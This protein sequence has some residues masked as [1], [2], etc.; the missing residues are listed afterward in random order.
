MKRYIKKFTA[1]LIFSAFAFFTVFFFA[2]AEVYLGNTLDF[3]VS[4]NSVIK[5][6]PVFAAAATLIFSFV[7]SFLPVKVLKIV[8]LSIFGIT[9]CFYIQAL[10]LNG[11]LAQLNGEK[12]VISKTTYISNIAIWIAILAVVFVCWLIFKKLKK[13]KAYITATKLVAVALVIMQL[14]GFISL[15]LKYDNSIS[16]LKTQ[17]LSS[18]GRFELSKQKNVVCFILDCAD[19]ETVNLALKEDP[20]MFAGLDGFTYYPDHIFIHGRTF[21]A[22]TYLLTKEK[23]YYDKPYQEYFNSACENSEFLA[24]LDSLCSD[25]RVYTEASYLGLTAMETVDNL[26]SNYSNDLSDIKLIG[27]IKHS[28]KISAF[29]EMPYLFKDYFAYKTEEV[30]KDSLVARDDVAPVN[31]DLEFYNTI[32]EQKLSLNESYSSAFRFYHMFGP[33]P[34]A[35]IDENAEYVA[36]ATLSQAMRGDMKIVK[37][38][39][40]QLKELGIYDNTTIIITADHGYFSGNVKIPQNCLLLV[41]EANADT[42]QP[43]KIS[44]AQVSQEDYFATVIKSFGGDYSKFGKAYDDISETE[45]RTRYHYNTE[46]N[47]DVEETLLKEYAITGDG[48]DLN[49]YKATGKE[50]EVKFS[51]NNSE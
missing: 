32:N 19:N 7:I 9:L 1:S 18:E 40:K 17:Y 24:S 33:H 45:N 22:M 36:E 20:D 10:F 50:W 47:S 49:N 46:I 39:I 6:L 11:S 31:D 15:F 26:S 13:E 51:R 4:I 48:R 30:N 35:T 37:T 42:S 44:Q 8:N 28:L 41:K 12:T 23:Y 29:R 2:P 5:V 14:T 3:Q 38:Y 43:L 27:F 25:V 16:Q 34:G 21:P